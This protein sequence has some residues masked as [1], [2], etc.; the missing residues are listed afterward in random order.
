MAT[1]VPAP[2]DQAKSAVPAVRIRSVDVL[3]G[4]VMVLMAIGHVPNSFT[5][6]CPY[7]IL[8]LRGS[9]ISPAGNLQNTRPPECKQM[10]EVYLISWGI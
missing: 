7:Y 5:G 2:G 9:C 4:A 1:P 8:L 3:R 10:V 6:I